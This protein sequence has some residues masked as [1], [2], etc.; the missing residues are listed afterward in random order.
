MKE[1][2]LVLI[3]GQRETVE[4]VVRKHAEIR[5]WILHAVNSKQMALAYYVNC[6]IQ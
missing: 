1:K 4:S 2:S 3:Q 6:Q 5:G